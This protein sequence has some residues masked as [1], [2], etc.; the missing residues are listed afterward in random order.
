MTGE[1]DPVSH[2][3]GELDGTVKNLVSQQSAVFRKIGE[4]ND[5]IDALIA[6]SLEHTASQTKLV[7]EMVTKNNAMFR[8]IDEDVDPQ[9]ESFKTFAARAEE[10]TKQRTRQRNIL[11]AAVPAI[12]VAINQVIE[13]FKGANPP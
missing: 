11:L 8:H 10:E 6:S 3:L 13:F 9:I 12:G 1:I 7:I 4:T 2:K 5:K